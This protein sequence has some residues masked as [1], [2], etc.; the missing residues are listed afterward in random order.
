MKKNGKPFE[1][2]PN[3][4]QMSLWASESY[5]NMTIR[6]DIWDGDISYNV[7]SS[8]L[9]RV[10]SIK[11]GDLV[12]T[13]EEQIALVLEKI[14]QDLQGFDVYRV[15]IEGKEFFYS[16]LELINFGE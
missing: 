16:A 5:C 15:M 3:N 14:S 4:G 12:Q 11:A 7:H 1:V 10:N 6:D 8:H 13:T 9:K 2:M